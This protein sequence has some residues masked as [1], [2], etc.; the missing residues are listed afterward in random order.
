MPA[1]T[2]SSTSATHQSPRQSARSH[3][4]HQWQNQAVAALLPVLKSK[5][6]QARLAAV[7][8]L[9]QFG[10]RAAPAIPG[11]RALKDDRDYEV[12]AAVAKAVLAIE[13]KVAP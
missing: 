3:P 8:A 10:P 6:W 4:S 1:L 2:T 5:D 7:N 11:L 9:S 13:D 12:K